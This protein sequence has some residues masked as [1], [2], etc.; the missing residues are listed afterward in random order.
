MSTPFNTRVRMGPL[1]LAVTDL[2]EATAK[3][4]ELGL[5][6]RSGTAIHLANAYTIALADKDDRYRDAVS[7][8]T[9]LPDG[10]P[11]TWISR[12]RRD[13]PPLRQTRG[14]SLFES[15]F[16]HGRP[17]G[18]RHYLLGSTPEVLELLQ[19][20]LEDRFP[21]VQIVGAESPA[22]RPLTDAERVKQDARI[23]ASG[24]HIVW[25]GLGTPKQDYEVARIAASLPVTAIAIGAA[26][27]F[28]AGT[29]KPAPSW[30]SRI[31]LEWFYRLL[32]EPR[33]LWRRYLFGNLGFLRA[34]VRAHS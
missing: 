5:M 3:I 15:V 29:V 34:V 28:V 27:D 14:P 9:A 19:A 16:D 4:V 7:S 18:V 17:R 10:K 11:I 24:A 12:L 20:N 6:C 31:G 30:M 22:F 21:G 25:V 1:S 8:G 13:L 33:R 32:R 2:E 26:F 23:E